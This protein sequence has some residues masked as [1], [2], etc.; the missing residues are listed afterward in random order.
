MKKEYIGDSVY[1]TYDGYGIE[2]TTE[3]GM[4]ATN[5][6]FIEP[7]VLASLIKFAQQMGVIK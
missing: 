6:I 7:S 1:A 3:N 5:H 4:G 2:L